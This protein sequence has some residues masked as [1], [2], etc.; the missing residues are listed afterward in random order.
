MRG[1]CSRQSKRTGVIPIRAAEKGAAALNQEAFQY[2]TKIFTE[3]EIDYELGELGHAGWELVT[4]QWEEFSF[5]GRSH[6]QARC[7]LKRRA[8]V[9]EFTETLNA[10]SA[11]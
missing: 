6:Q 8:R 2:L 9:D 5:G 7:I 11:S 10:I 3:R 1:Q 4:A